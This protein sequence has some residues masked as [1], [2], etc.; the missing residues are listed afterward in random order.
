MVSYIKSQ[1][2]EICSELLQ[3]YRFMREVT[4]V[5]NIPALSRTSI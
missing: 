5:N 2:N 1:W 3:V 4:V